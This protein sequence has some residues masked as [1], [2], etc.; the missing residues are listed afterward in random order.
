MMLRRPILLALV[1]VTLLL[2]LGRLIAGAGDTAAPELERPELGPEAAL[3]KGADD[4]PHLAQSGRVN[5]ASI[6]VI[7]EAQDPEAAEVEEETVL[8]DQP[9]NEQRVLYP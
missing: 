5:E 7:A 3:D 6:D 4:L 2:G 8:S 1:A 9:A